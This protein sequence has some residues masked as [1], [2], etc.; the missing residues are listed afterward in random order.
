MRFTKV[1][2]F[3]LYR[4]N[5]PVLEG[6]CLSAFAL[7]DSPPR[8]YRHP[9]HPML[10]VVQL[11]KKGSMM[12]RNLLFC[13]ATLLTGSIL[14]ADATPKD[15]VA[16]A[17][18]KLAEKP[19]YSWRTTVVVPEDSPFHPGPTDGKIEKDGFTRVKLDFGDNTTEFV[20]KGGKAAVTNPDGGWQALSELDDSDGPG[21]F[22]GRMIRNFKAPAVQ[23][24]EIAASTKELKKDGDVYSSDL[25]EEGAKALLLFRRG[26]D[27][28][29]SN[30]KGS[31][32]FWIKDGALSKYEFKVKG[33]VNFNGN[34]M[35]ID[36][37]STVEIKDVGTTKLDV[38]EEAKKKLQ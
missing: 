18:K 36:R 38:P 14:A 19:N 3:S 24:G 7:A 4:S 27:A 20:L 15:D 8:N 26:G 28:T 37:A 13:L 11:S 29:A 12:K 33:N 30:A 10:N 2:P 5:L 22:I 23:A 31:A 16:N 1:Q 9:R 25:T 35:D 21:R 17:A 34:D 6:F 32:K